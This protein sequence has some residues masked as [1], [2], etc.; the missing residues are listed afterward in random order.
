MQRDAAHKGKAPSAPHRR[1]VPC[2][3]K[4]MPAVIRQQLS[5]GFARHTG[6]QSKAVVR[7]VR[8]QL[9]GITLRPYY[10]GRYDRADRTVAAPHAVKGKCTF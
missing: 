10:R 7:A 3:K 8:H 4:S 6:G 1:L 5:P 2:G 9:R